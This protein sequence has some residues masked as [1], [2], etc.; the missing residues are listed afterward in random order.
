MP[1]LF[2]RY[3]H[4]CAIVRST[5]WADKSSLQ[6]YSASQVKDAPWQVPPFAKRSKVSWSYNLG[7]W[8]SHGPSQTWKCSGMAYTYQT[9]GSQK[10]CWF[11]FLLSAPYSR[12]QLHS[13]T[14]SHFDQE[15]CSLLLVF[16]MRISISNTERKVHYH[17]CLLASQGWRNVHPGH[18][19]LKILY[20]SGSLAIAR[21]RRTRSGLRQSTLQS[22]WIKLLYEAPRAFS[23]CLF[24]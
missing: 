23:S 14:T 18:W 4:L 13:P 6:T 2:R 8:Y 24:C 21:R 19:C 7:A 9:E 1:S 15:K 22:H 10:V 3:Y 20:W 5:F 12:F 16:R 17:S 11:M